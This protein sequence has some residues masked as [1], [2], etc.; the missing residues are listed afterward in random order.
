MNAPGIDP[1]CGMKVAADS[2]HHAMHGGQHFGFC[3]ASCRT[4]F[5]ADPVRYT[6]EAAPDKAPHHEHQHHG[7]AAPSPEAPKTPSDAIYTCP[8]HPEIRHVGPGS[9]PICGMALEPLNATES[10]GENAELKDMQRRFW[11]GAALSVPVVL[12]EMGAHL[13]ALNLHHLI[14]AR[15]SQWVQFVLAT[16]VILWAGWP[17]FTRAVASVRNRS[18]NMFSLIGLGVAATTDATRHPPRAAGA[19]RPLVFPA[20]R[21]DEAL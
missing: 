21:I 9:C 18:L 16:P 11:I 7:H 10:S 5:L 20:L 15:I 1:V 12:L 17:F 3:S 19:E 13:P 6:T 4:K 2:P 8:M 14:G